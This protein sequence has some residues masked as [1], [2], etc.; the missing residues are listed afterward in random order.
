MIIPV[1]NPDKADM[2]LRATRKEA[3]SVTL[4]PT[5]GW[6]RC[7]GEDLPSAFGPMAASSS[8]LREQL[9]RIG[10]AMNLLKIVASATGAPRDTS[11]EIHLNVELLRLKDREDRQGQVVP[12][13]PDLTLQVGEFIGF[14]VTNQG[15]G[16][17][18]VTLLWV[19]GNYHITA[20]FPDP[21]RPSVDNRLQPVSNGG[22]PLLRR[23][24]ITEEGLGK[25]HLVVI[26]VA[27]RALQ[28]RGDFSFLAQ[29]TF[30]DVE[31]EVRTRGEKEIATSID[32]S[33]GRLFQNALYARGNTTRGGSSLDEARGYSLQAISWRSRHAEKEN[34]KGN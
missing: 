8:A 1:D 9:L 28:G 11:D 20:V 31:R 3:D 6:A 17:A 33:L 4:I 22:Q 30:A 10:Q 24:A 14:R 13:Q 16:A 21:D 23:F 15:P 2:L 5:Q 29:R 34:A 18:D 26:A 25:E 7:R 19:D 12:L 27:P 32:S